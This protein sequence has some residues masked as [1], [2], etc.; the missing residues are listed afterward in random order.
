MAWK[1]KNQV[2]G[3]IKNYLWSI[4]SLILKQSTNSSNDELSWFLWLM[5]FMKSNLI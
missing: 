5:L 3:K 2:T 1:K 4:L